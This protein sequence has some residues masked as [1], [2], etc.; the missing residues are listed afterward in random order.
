LFSPS[1]NY[2][3]GLFTDGFRLYGGKKFD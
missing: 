2:L 3:V 1:G